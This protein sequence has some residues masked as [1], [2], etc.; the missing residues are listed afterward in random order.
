M[1]RNKHIRFDYAIKK[2]LREKA[3]FGILSG[4]LSELLR[5]DLKVQEILESESNK[6]N[7]DDKF[8]RVDILVKNTIGDLI[9]IEVQNDSESDY[10]HRMHY[11]QAKLLTEHIFKGDSYDNLKKIY[12]INIVYFGLG[13]GKDYIYKGKTEFKGLH[14]N[15]LLELTK[16]QKE[17][18]LKLQEVSDIFTTYYIIKVNNF[19]KLSKDSLDEWIYFLK[20][21]EI[22]DEFKAKG[23]E[24]AKEK[25]RVDNFTDEEKV[26]YD[27]FIKNRRINKTVFEDAVLKGIFKG[28]KEGKKEGIIEGKKEGKKEGIIEG[29]IEGRKEA[30][31]ELK[32]IIDKQNKTIVTIMIKQGASNEEIM[33]ET[34]LS[35]EEIKKI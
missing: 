32:S 23:L 24:E 16:F 35:M 11:A 2:L 27:L 9:L 26:S 17:K 3:N 22:K 20:T 14:N 10:F 25:M 12:S 21:S 5:E 34:G 1:I 18:Y 6:E 8:N 30:E 29:K 15:D 28:K 31:E 13:Q 19:D 33:K 4:F 7:F